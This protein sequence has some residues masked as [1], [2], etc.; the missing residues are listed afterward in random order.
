MALYLLTARCAV[1]VRGLAGITA[2]L[3]FHV[4]NVWPSSWDSRGKQFYHQACIPSHQGQ[5]IVKIECECAHAFPDGFIA[6]W[7]GL[8]GTTTNCSATSIIHDCT[9]IGDLGY[10]RGRH[11]LLGAVAC[12]CLPVVICE[13]LALI[14]HHNPCIAILCC[15]L[16]WLLAEVI[17]SRIV[18]APNGSLFPKLPLYYLTA[19]HPTANPRALCPDHLGVMVYSTSLLCQV[20]MW[21]PSL[22]STNYPQLFLDTHFFLLYM[23]VLTC[24]IFVLKKGGGIKVGKRNWKRVKHKN[25]WL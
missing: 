25:R 21:N 7:S 5:F 22:Q 17:P 16:V 2:I 24:V 11:A 10:A 19:C 8:T 1:I 23:K 18:S 6:H 20:C 4:A 13:W 15:V 3:L 9:C 12:G 14:L